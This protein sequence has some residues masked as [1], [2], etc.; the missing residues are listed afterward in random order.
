MSL[1]RR[2]TQAAARRRP[3]RARRARA[4]PPRR[5]SCPWGPLPRRSRRSTPRRHGARA[6]GAAPPPPRRRTGGRE[7]LLRRRR[8][9][10]RFHLRGR[11]MQG[12]EG[13]AAATPRTASSWPSVAW[14][15][16]GRRGFR[17][18]HEVWCF[19]RV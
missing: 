11:G 1:R 14:R 10:R 16:L 13:T 12:C 9:R 15:R 2:G 17:R 5:G 4:S 19:G 8:P 6:P 7:F 3:W 18:G